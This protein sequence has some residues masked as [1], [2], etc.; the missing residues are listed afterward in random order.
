MR[1]WP[2]AEKHLK[3]SE[4]TQ[5]LE[6]LIALITEHQQELNALIESGE[7][8]SLGRENSTGLINIDSRAKD[9]SDLQIFNR[10]TSHSN[11]SE[12]VPS[13]FLKKAQENGIFELW[14]FCM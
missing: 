9:T 11:I 4:Q 13:I 5:L 3:H 1:D 14:R 12:C 10:G 7:A 2:E 6:H 8:D